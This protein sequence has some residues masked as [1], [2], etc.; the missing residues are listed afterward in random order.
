M[1]A[2]VIL[3]GDTGTGKSELFA[4]Y[5]TIVNSDCNLVPDL[6]FELRTALSRAVNRCASSPAMKD[7]FIDS[8]TAS[9][10]RANRVDAFGDDNSATRLLGLL[11]VCARGMFWRQG[12]GQCNVDVFVLFRISTE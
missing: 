11:E 10:A 9:G 3:S 4:V 12:C 1:G 5:S 8:T 6:I 2:N 7:M